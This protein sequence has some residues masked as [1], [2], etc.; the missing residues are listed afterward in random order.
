MSIQTWLEEFSPIDP[1]TPSLTWA[2]ATDIAIKAWEGKKNENLEKHEI[3]KAPIVGCSLCFKG[4]VIAFEYYNKFPNEYPDPEKNCSFC[5]IPKAIG[6]TCKRVCNSY[7]GNLTR[8]ENM[9]SILRKTKEY[10]L[11][12]PN[13]PD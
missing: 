2:E 7:S 1:T 12:H 5:P 13:H 6:E 4:D 9:L 11:T 3:R 8:I 10:L